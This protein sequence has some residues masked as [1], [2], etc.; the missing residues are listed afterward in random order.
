VFRNC[1]VGKDFLGGRNNA[2]VV[3][4]CRIPPLSTLHI[5]FPSSD[6]HTKNLGQ[7]RALFDCND[8]ESE[9]HGTLVG[10]YVKQKCVTVPSRCCQSTCKFHAQPITHSTQDT[11]DILEKSLE[12][13]VCHHVSMSSD[14]VAPRRQ[15]PTLTRLD[16]TLCLHLHSDSTPPHRCRPEHSTTSLHVGRTS[17]RLTS[18]QSWEGI[19]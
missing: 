6:N 9:G 15:P 19:I 12:S 5:E 10:A 16:A 2:K 13:S 1:G 18:W 3:V 4:C 14:T 17:Q 7:S 8:L 11:H